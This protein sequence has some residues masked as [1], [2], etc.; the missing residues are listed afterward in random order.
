M[1]Y[2]KLF[3]PFDGTLHAKDAMK[4]AAA[5]V[6][7]DPEAEIIFYRVVAGIS[8][9]AMADAGLLEQ[10]AEVR[11]AECDE[12]EAAIRAS[13]AELIPDAPNPITVDVSYAPSPVDG[14][15]AKAEEV[16]AEAIVMGARG[17]NM[18]EGAVG[19]ACFGVIR[20]AKIPVTVVK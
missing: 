5:M 8:D 16:G 17:K 2:K 4:L 1:L 9:K 18:A 14:I 6:A 10:Y 11:K 15:L 7:D 3:V 20:S 13:I 19:S 12:I